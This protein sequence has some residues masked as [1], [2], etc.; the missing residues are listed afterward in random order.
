MDEQLRE[1]L[2]RAAVE[3]L[4]REQELKLLAAVLAAPVLAPR[5]GPRSCAR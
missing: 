2:Y 5:L 3:Q 1:A 4:R